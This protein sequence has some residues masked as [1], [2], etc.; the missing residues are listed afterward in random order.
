MS[1][2]VDKEILKKHFFLKCKISTIDG[3]IFDLMKKVADARKILHQLEEEMAELQNQHI[4][5]LEN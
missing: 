2:Q 5:D 3:I 1:R 4:S